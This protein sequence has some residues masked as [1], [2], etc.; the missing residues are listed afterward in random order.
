MLPTNLI[1]PNYPG[2]GAITQRVF[3]DELYRNYNAIQLE[4][5]RRLAE[6]SGVGRELY[7]LGHQA[8]HGL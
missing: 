7:R 3:L 2:R 6:W 1:R 8:V 5:R 4:V